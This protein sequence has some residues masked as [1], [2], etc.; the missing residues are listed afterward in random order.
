MKSL[1]TLLAALAFAALPASAVEQWG[2]YEIALPGPADGNPFVDTTLS[3]RFTQ[4]DR[5]IEA[6][7]FYDGDGTYRIRFMPGTAGEWKYETRSNR[8]EL[9]GKSGAFT[10]T[11]PA[12]GNH[13]PVSV[14]HT[15]HFAYADG[16]PYCQI[17]TTCYSWAHADD[18]HEELTLKTLASAPFNKLRMCVFPQDFAFDGQASPLPLRGHAPARLGL[19][20]VRPGLLPPPRRA[21]RPAPR[22]GDRGRPDPLPPLRQEMGLQRDEPGQ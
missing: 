7:G 18:A 11:A 15:Y 5:T 4:G 20:P 22:P 13:G 3:A 21:G 9:T 12:A 14:R 6:E 16:T 10:A 2:L 1:L 17:G 8:P 19:R